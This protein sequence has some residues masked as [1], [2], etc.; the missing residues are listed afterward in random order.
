MVSPSKGSL[1][2]VGL[3]WNSSPAGWFSELEL[4]VDK[5]DQI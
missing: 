5:N 4:I 3:S 2:G 1:P